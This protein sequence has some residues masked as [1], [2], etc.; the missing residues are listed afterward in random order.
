MIDLLRMY[1]LP[2]HFGIKMTK[3]IVVVVNITA[4]NV[5]TLN[6]KNMQMLQDMRFSTHKQ[7]TV[8]HY[9]NRCPI[10]CHN[11]FIILEL[12]FAT[13]IVDMHVKLIT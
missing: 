4:H 8:R 2:T 12:S 6:G 7:L 13:D 11:T 5:T 1:L 9:T 10:I 3:D